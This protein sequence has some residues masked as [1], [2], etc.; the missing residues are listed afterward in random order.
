MFPRHLSRLRIRLAAAVTVPLLASALALPLVGTAG[1]AAAGSCG[2]ASGCNRYELIHAGS[3]YGWYPAATRN[4]FITADGAR[5]PRT[6]SHVGTPFA[7]SDKFGTLQI[8]QHSGDLYTDWNR[9]HRT[10]RWEVRFRSKTGNQRTPSGAPYQVKI[11]LVPTGTRATRCAPES[12]L[13]AGYDPATAG[14]TARV[15]VTRPGF[16]ASAP[17]T[18]VGPLFDVVKWN[19]TQDEHV[20]AW[21]VWAVE[22][23][24]DHISWFLDGRVIR[25]ESRPAA[26]IGKPLHLRLSLL[27]TSPQMAPAMTQL[28]WARYWTLKRTT[29]ARKKVRALRHAPGLTAT[30]ASPA[31]GC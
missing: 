14:R 12:V 9:S 23:G 7:W 18:P 6:W 15:G 20:G 11:E 4:E 28:D 8:E 16:R 2:R 22:V 26:L 1:P 27:A 3:T 19:G 31:P 5:P 30:T 25:R 24:R 10:G 21:R 17:A 29:K 13:M